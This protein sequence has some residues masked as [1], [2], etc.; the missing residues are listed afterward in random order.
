ML[1]QDI[2]NWRAESSLHHFL[3]NKYFP[4]PSLLFSTTFQEWH[5]KATIV[6][7]GKAILSNW[8]FNLEF[9][10]FSWIAFH[11][12]RIVFCIYIFR[13]TPSFEQFECKIWNAIS[14]QRGHR[15]AELCFNKFQNTQKK[16]CWTRTVSNVLMKL[17][18]SGIF[19]FPERQ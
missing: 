5:I 10:R 19:V 2:T 8:K 11:L 3:P 4:Y 6:A 14:F 16:T 17:Y 18:L 12:A 13:G 9:G 7:T 15:A 1:T